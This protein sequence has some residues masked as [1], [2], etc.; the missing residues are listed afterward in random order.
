MSKS[1][2]LICHEDVRVPVKF[3]CFRCPKQNST[4]NLSIGPSCNDRIRVCMKCARN[5]LQLNKAPGERDSNRK[6]LICD[7]R[8]NLSALTSA[9]SCYEKDYYSMGND[10]CAD[11]LC[12]HSEK[13][14]EFKGTQNELDRHMQTTCQYRTTS[15]PCGS[16]YRVCDAQQHF[17]SCARYRLC[18]DCDTYVL[19]TDFP[20]HLRDNHSKMI[21]PHEGCNK[22]MSRDSFNVHKDKCLYRTLTCPRCSQRVPAKLYSTHIMKHIRACQQDIRDYMEGIDKATREMDKLIEVQNGLALEESDT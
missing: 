6:C 10:S 22:I 2:C 9:S 13:G 1:V 16:L 7:T 17:S 3:T 14:C 4:P 12:F 8:V 19:Y 21:C 18:P 15:C 20:Y 11:Y 5:Y